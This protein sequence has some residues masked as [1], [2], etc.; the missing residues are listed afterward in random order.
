MKIFLS[1]LAISA[2]IVFPGTAGPKEKPKTV[3]GAPWAPVAITAYIQTGADPECPDG[4]VDGLFFLPTHAQLAE[5]DKSIR[6]KQHREYIE[7]SWDCDDMMKEWVVLTHRWAIDN[8]THKAPIALATF[9]A[10]VQIHPGAFDG[11][12]KS[13]GRHAVGLVLDSDGV[14]WAVD[15]QSLMHVKVQEA[16]FEGTIEFE[17]IV[18]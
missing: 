16:L 4:P 17:K 12:W 8:V 15:C 9:G 5:M 18:W 3:T 1:C 6:P 14:W 11:R 13:E 10:Y 7:E 2:A